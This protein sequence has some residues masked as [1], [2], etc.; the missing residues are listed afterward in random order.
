MYKQTQP[1][2][3]RIFASLQGHPVSPVEDEELLEE[4]ELVEAEVVPRELVSISA[5]LLS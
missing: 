5:L 2:Q 3:I 1:P 4:P